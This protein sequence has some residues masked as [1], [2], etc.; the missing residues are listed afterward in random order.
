LCYR[1]FV[2]D[3]EN[4]RVSTQN[5]KGLAFGFTKKH[6]F[7]GKT[8]QK[9]IFHPYEAHI[10]SR[11]NGSLLYINFLRV[12]EKYQVLAQNLGLPSVLPKNIFSQ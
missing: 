11:L 9:S 1:E 4:Y 10:L 7:T 3:F 5:P 2:G 6:L 8:R 12:F